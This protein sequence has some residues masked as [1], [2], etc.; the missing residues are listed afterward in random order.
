MDHLILRPHA[1]QQVDRPK[2]MGKIRYCQFFT[3]RAGSCKLPGLK[4]PCNMKILLP[5]L[6]S[7]LNKHGS[8]VDYCPAMI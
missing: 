8:F 5:L 1:E 3:N 7:N 6:K 4:Q 2:Y